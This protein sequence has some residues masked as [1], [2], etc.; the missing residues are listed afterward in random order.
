MKK[1]ILLLLLIPFCL[2]ATEVV[3]FKKGKNVTS[4]ADV[5]ETNVVPR[6]QDNIVELKPVP[7]SPFKPQSRRGFNKAN[8]VPR[9]EG[10]I[11]RKK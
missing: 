10:N 5:K 3:V 9:N 4:P 11:V 8:I 1:L 2:Q 6:N 7:Q